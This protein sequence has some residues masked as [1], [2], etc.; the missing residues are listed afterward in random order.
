MMP[1]QTPIIAELLIWSH[2]SVK[3]GYSPY[4]GVRPPPDGSAWVCR[5][6]RFQRVC[7]PFLGTKRKLKEFHA[8]FANYSVQRGALV[9]HLVHDPDQRSIPNPNRFWIYISNRAVYLKLTH[10]TLIW[11]ISGSISVARDI[12]KIAIGAFGW[13]SHVDDDGALCDKPWLHQEFSCG[14]KYH[15]NPFISTWVYNLFILKQKPSTE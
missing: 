7:A 15:L 8:W 13:Y 10:A 1:Q 14:L 3:P 6:S 2:P 5:R 12:I 4:L 9:A 11:C